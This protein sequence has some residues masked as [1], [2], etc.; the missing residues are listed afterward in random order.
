MRV[1]EGP[2]FLRSQET[3]EPV[4]PGVGPTPRGRVQPVAMH[5]SVQRAEAHGVPSPALCASS[6]RT[7]Q[8]LLQA[9]TWPLAQVASQPDGRAQGHLSHLGSDPN[10]IYPTYWPAWFIW[11]FKCH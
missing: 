2:S 11:K 8:L 4:S 9:E 6:S 10:W 5:G 3:N 7:Q 1:G